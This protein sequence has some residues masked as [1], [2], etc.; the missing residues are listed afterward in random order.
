MPGIIV[1]MVSKKVA[2]GKLYNCKLRITDV[3]SAYQFM[4]VPCDEK[5][6]DNQLIVYENLREKDLETVMPK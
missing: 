5:L 2:E 1:R 3:F 6:G 4:A